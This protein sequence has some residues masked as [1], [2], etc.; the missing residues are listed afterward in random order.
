MEKV[1]IS[2]RQSDT[3]TIPGSLKAEANQSGNEQSTS[4]DDKKV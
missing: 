3:H 2:K 4:I 1:Q